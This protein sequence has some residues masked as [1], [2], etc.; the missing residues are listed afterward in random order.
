MSSQLLVLNKV[1]PE[2]ET[3]ATAQTFG[4]ISV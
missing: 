3:E 4:R 2:S 1:V